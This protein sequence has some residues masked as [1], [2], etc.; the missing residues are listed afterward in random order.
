[1]RIS[2]ASIRRLHNLLR[3]R[4]GLD[5]LF[6]LP[7]ALGK[8]VQP[9]LDGVIEANRFVAHRRDL[10]RHRLDTAGEHGDLPG[11]FRRRLADLLGQPGDALM[12][13]A[14][15]VAQRRGVGI[16]FGALDAL[17][18]AREGFGLVAARGLDLG[19]NGAQDALRFALRP[20]ADLDAL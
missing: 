3:A 2:A 20:L 17:G 12:Q 8:G 15:G 11:R 7:D 1:M 10:E 6:H 13:P 5:Q 14:H 18:E 9:F 16:P 19:G 4:C